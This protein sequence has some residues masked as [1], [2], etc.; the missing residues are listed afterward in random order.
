MVRVRVLRSRVL[1][2]LGATLFVAGGSAGPRDA[3]ATFA[4]FPGPGQVSY[5]EP[6][7]YKAEFETT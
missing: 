7:A 1:V 5:G 4:A 6:I 2:V 3:D